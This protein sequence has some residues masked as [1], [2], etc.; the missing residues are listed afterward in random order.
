MDF[1][2]MLIEIDKLQHSVNQY[3]NEQPQIALATLAVK[4]GGQ[5][6]IVPV[7]RMP[8]KTGIAAIYRY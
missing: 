4:M 3:I 5:V 7:E 8:T 1:R 2:G 6:V